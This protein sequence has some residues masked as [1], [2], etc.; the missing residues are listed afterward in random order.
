MDATELEIHNI[1]KMS[2]ANSCELDPIP[3]CIFLKYY[4]PVFNLTF[5]S[6]INMFIDELQID[7]DSLSS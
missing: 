3:T 4:R 5:I 2:P 1:I 7:K 6:E